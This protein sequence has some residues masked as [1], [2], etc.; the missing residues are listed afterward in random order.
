MYTDDPTYHSNFVAHT[1][2]DAL[3]GKQTQLTSN[4]SYSC[5]K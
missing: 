2:H 3:E 4:L 1:L 5:L